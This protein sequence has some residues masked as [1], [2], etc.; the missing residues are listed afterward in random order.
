MSILSERTER[1]ALLEIAKTLRFFERLENLKV[2]NGDAFGI[3]K[4]E[5]II[6]GIISDNGYRSDFSPKRGT[7]IGRDKTYKR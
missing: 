1:K 5:N 6:K 4:A 3:R 2:S 7:T